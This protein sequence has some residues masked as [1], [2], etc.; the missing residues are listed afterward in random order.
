[1]KK[2]KSAGHDK[3]TPE[4]LKNVGPRGSQLI[5]EIFNRAWKQGE[6]QKNGKLAVSCQYSKKETKQT[7]QTIVS[8]C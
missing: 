6:Y 5:K 3:I 7:V 2:G 4:M 1:M 8:H